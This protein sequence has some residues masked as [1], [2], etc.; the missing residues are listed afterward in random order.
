MALAIARCQIC[1]HSAAMH[2]MP[3]VQY[4]N[5]WKQS[6][7]FWTLHFTVQREEL[8]SLEWRKNYTVLLMKQPPKLIME[9]CFLQ[10][11]KTTNPKYL[12]MRQEVFSREE[13][14]NYLSCKKKNHI[15]TITHILIFLWGPL[16]P[17]SD[18]CEQPFLVLLYAGHKLALNNTN[19]KFFQSCD[20]SSSIF[21]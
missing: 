3:V 20:S 16:Y 5:H 12:K 17:A 4:V 8:H 7:T 18:C 9:S 13:L 1:F 10:T 15:H 19:L 11:S 21:R 2:R 6:S 14:T